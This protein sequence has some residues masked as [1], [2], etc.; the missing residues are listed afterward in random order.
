MSA[1]H[2]SW[3]L[4]QAVSSFVPVAQCVRT[5]GRRTKV[6]GS[7]ANPIAEACEAVKL[8]FVQAYW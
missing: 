6:A 2:A 1:E 3:P 5:T 4:A 7:H 8:A